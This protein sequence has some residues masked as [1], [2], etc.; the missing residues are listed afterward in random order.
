MI[1]PRGK[2]DTGQRQKLRVISAGTMLLAIG[3]WACAMV[4]E[5]TWA[6]ENGGGSAGPSP[7]AKQGEQ[8]GQ[9][10]EAVGPVTLKHIQRSA[11]AA[12][13]TFGPVP[14]G[15]EFDQN[16]ANQIPAGP[17]GTQGNVS[18]APP[19][20]ANEGQSAAPVLGTNFQ[21]IGATGFRPADPH[22]AVGPSHIVQVVNSTLRISNKSGGTIATATLESIFGKPTG[23]GFLFD[24]WVEYDHFANRFVVVSIATNS[25]Q[26]DS[27]YIVAVTKTA[28]PSTSGGNWWVYY[29]RS[30]LDGT[31]NT[32]FWSDYEKLGFDNTYFYITSNQ[33]NSSGTFQYSKI[34]RYPKS[35]IYG[36]GTVS[37]VEWNIVR[38]PSGNKVFTIQPAVTFGTPGTEYLVSSSSGAGAS[39]VVFRIPQSG[40]T[41]FSNTIATNSWSFPDN[42]AQ[43][44]S[45]TK[46][47]VG[48]CRLLNAVYR[49]G[50]LY[51]CHTVKRGS[52]PCAC[53]YI[54]VNTSNLT[55]SLDVTIGFG[56]GS[57]LPPYYYSFPAVAVSG[58]GNLG[59]VFNFA[60]SDRFEGATYTQINLNGTIQPLAL[61]K[62]GQASYVK[63]DSG[64][65]RWGD[66][67][68]ICVDPSNT[69]RL[70]FNS[71]WA[72]STANTWG[73][74]VGST[75]LT[76]SSPAAEVRVA[77]DPASNTLTLIGDDAANAVQVRSIGGR[78]IVS[79]Q[80]GTLINGKQSVTLD[81]PTRFS[82]D[83]NLAGGDDHLT[84][85][86]LNLQRAHLSLG[87][88]NDSVLL[89]LSS[90]ADLQADGGD[91]TDSIVA[92]SSNVSQ[93]DQANFP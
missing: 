15:K 61:L 22:L 17:T 53:H 78:V 69:S 56:G 4:G 7:S 34:R 37:A 23:A 86:G 3:W 5:R 66:Y 91:G 27:W 92:T 55:K 39:L 79:G 26:T 83:A 49:G 64:E 84:L 57:G 18:A 81:A 58:G 74:W 43:K 80:G 90:V 63:L 76:A 2:V 6:A 46:I 48:D 82:L 51:T 33:F 1:H 24:P 65:N 77:F 44:G 54:G 38:D 32:A 71:M 25:A 52:F 85:I 70:W 16:P 62:E 47:D 30:D 13:P 40:T 59:T 67:N 75:A 29:F 68:G 19:P 10:V 60:A 20:A 89:L 42:A 9:A 12:A 93:S 28:T 21:G 73:T 87:D 72:T 50:R 36:G 31:T 45:S 14:R 88:G 35:A 8:V 41:L 11:E